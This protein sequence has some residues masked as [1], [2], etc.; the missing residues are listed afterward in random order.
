[1][2]KLITIFSI[3]LIASCG[4]R[5][6]D[7]SKSDTSENVKVESEEKSTEIVKSDINTITKV[8][9]TDSCVEIVP[10]DTT[11]P[12]EVIDYKGLKTTY[13]NAILKHQKK[14]INTN[15]ILNDK[16][17]KTKT[18]EVATVVKQSKKENVKTKKTEKEYSWL[19]I[20]WLLIPALIIMIYI[21][22]K[23]IF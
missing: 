9:V 10:I 13:K 7:T 11:K 2:K 1:M 19:N 14:E 23:D 16:S 21:R 15:I 18:K 8:E 17:V 22:F 12:I 3:I 4:A 5:K 6:T 20:F